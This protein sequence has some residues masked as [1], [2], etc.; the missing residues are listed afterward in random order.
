M[1]SKLAK[2]QMMLPIFSN[3]RRC[4]HRSDGQQWRSGHGAMAQSTSLAIFS[5]EV[6]HR[7]DPAM[8]RIQQGQNYFDTKSR[9][10]DKL[11][12]LKTG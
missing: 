9:K 12:N 1:D 7:K 8:Q 5:Q 6:I 11:S 2:F 4:S 10:F 3:V